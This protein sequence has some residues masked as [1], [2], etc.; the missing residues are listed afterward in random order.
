MI[1]EERKFDAKMLQELE[2][3]N[4]SKVPVYSKYRYNIIG[5]IKLKNL[6]V[7]KFGELTSLKNSG[8]VQ[9]IA[10]LNENLTLLDAIDQLK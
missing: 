7:F 2:E 10:K 1:N 4:Y 3:H 9:P 8:I 5:Y 6:L